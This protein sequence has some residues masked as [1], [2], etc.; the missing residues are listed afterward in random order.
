MEFTNDWFD[1][2]IPTWNRIVPQYNPSRILEVGS[3][4]GRSVCH[5]IE[6]LGSQKS[7]E[8]V[9]VDTW[10]G[11]REHADIDMGSVERRF[12]ANVGEAIS[13]AGQPVTVKKMK[14]HSC[15]ALSALVAE[16]R[17][18]YF[19]MVYVDGSHEAPDVLADA[20]LC[21]RLLREGGLMIF[22]DYLWGTGSASGLLNSPKPAIDAFMNCYAGKVQQHPWLPGYQVYARKIC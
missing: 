8:I 11:G 13:K 4:E 10:G 3:Y 6:L 5:V 20:V 7:L 1:P 19:D 17:S 21:Y 9:C 14:G 2:H 18:N 15:I 16:G 22:D 12:D